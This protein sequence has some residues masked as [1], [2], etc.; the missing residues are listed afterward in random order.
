M[1]YSCH[2]LFLESKQYFAK[3]TCCG[4]GWV[5]TGMLAQPKWWYE[6]TGCLWVLYI[7]CIYEFPGRV[8]GQEIKDTTFSYGCMASTSHICK[9]LLLL[10][11]FRYVVLQVYPLLDNTLFMQFSCLWFSKVSKNDG[12]SNG[13]AFV[14][15]L[16]WM[17]KC[18]S[19]LEHIQSK[20]Y[21]NAGF[22]LFQWTPA[23]LLDTVFYH[24]A[25]L[26]GTSVETT[27]AFI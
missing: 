23:V 13:V 4:S 8:Y 14:R 10:R 7:L 26:Q 15:G 6:C 12:S 2:W 9:A 20:L 25:G 17:W 21:S 24:C 1:L 22:A 11:D 3:R 27:D 5:R 19:Q 18:V 16:L